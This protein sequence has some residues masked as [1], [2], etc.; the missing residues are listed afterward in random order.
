MKKLLSILLLIINQ[1]VVAGWFGPSNYDECVLDG[2]KN[3]S[4]QQPNNEAVIQACYSRFPLPPEPQ[5]PNPLSLNP[6]WIDIDIYIVQYELCMSAFE[7][8][9]AENKRRLGQNAPIWAPN[10]GLPPPSR[11]YQPPDER[12]TDY[13]NED[14]PDVPQD[15]CE[16]NRRCG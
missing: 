5:K 8:R 11:T 1:E 2:S 6:E 7:R 10:C 9:Y 16:I 13:M 3:K 4:Q 12:D 15:P 14:M